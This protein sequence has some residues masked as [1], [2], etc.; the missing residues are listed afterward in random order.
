MKYQDAINIEDLRQIAQKRLPRF[1]FSYVDGGS[2]DE[3]TLA[4]NLDALSQWR[5]KPRTLIDV[6]SRDTSGPVLGGPAKMPVI[7]GPTGLNGLS[8]RDGDLEMAQAAATVGVPFAASTVCMSLLE[9]VREQAGGRLMFQAYVFTERRI[10]DALIERAREAGFETLIITSDFPVAGKRERDYRSGM[11]PKQQFP[12]STK[13]DILMHPR[14]LARVATN[15]PRFVNVEREL[16]PGK[17]VNNFVGHGMFD[18]SLNW[19]DLKRFRDRWPGKMLLKG[20]LRAEDAQRAVSMGLDGIVLSNH[21]GRQLDSAISGLDAL[22]E[23]A[24]AIGGKASIIVDGGVRRGSDIAKAIAL[25][26]EAVILGRA[27]VYG[28]AAGGR[29]GAIK[30]LEILQEELDTTL[31]L[32]GCRSIRD[33]SPD[34]LV[35]Q[36]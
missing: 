1:V 22:P 12:L 35:K 5:F 19:D 30:A 2:G 9:D 26:A 8:W 10:T 25:G 17:D 23:V 29:E 36:G 4:R 34:L 15:R 33:L 13:L 6:S 28:L 31:A 7:V 24:A 3:R 27:P 11:L 32:T 20:V 21:G 18:P 16:G 14:W